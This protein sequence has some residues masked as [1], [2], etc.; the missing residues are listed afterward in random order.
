MD[1]KPRLLDLFCC[2]GGAGE[3]YRRAGFDVVGVDIWPQPRYPHEFIEA[4]A[5]DFLQAHGRE[6][7]AIHASPPC[8]RFV[9]GGLVA[10]RDKLPDL[11]GPVRELLQEIGRPWVIENVPGAPLRADLML[12]GSMFGL[13]LRRHRIFESTAPMPLTPPCDHSG[14]IVGVYGHPHGKRG[15]WPGMLPST[16]STWS[17]AMGIDWMDAHGLAEAIPPAYTEFIGRALIGSS[18]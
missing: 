1:R 15:A 8:Q 13:T 11:V 3:G 6:F 16:M 14:K 5:L 10:N 2:Q 7:D 9:T 18:S 12:C 17:A 4:G